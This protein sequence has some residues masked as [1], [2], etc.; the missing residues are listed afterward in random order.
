VGFTDTVSILIFTLILLSV[1]VYL[2][3]S[4]W[5]IGPLKRLKPAERVLLSTML[6]GVFMVM[7]YAAVELLFHVV[8]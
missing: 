2:I 4:R 5:V 8:F 3:M 6:V 7:T 1:T